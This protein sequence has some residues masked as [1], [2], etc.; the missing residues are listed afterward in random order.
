MIQQVDI[1]N[2]EQ[3]INTLFKCLDIYRRRNAYKDDELRMG[4]PDLWNN[5][6][7]AEEFMQ[8]ANANKK[9]LTKYDECVSALDDVKINMMLLSE[10]NCTEADIDNAYKTA[11]KLIT[12]IELSNMLQKEEDQLGA[13]LKIVAGAGGTE[14]C[15]FA[16]MLARM[17][18]QYF[19]SLGLT[20]NKD[21]VVADSQSDETSGG[22]KTVSF[23][24]NT[25]GMFG[26]L[27]AETGVHRLV[28]V[29]PFNAQ[30]KRM[31]SFVSVFVTPLID[32]SFEIE[33]DE[34]KLKFEY[35][36][37]SGAGGQ[38]V[39]KVE[40]G[41]RARYMYIDPDT[42]ESEEILVENTE[43]RDQPKNKANAIRILKSILYD[44]E[45]K[46]RQKA[47]DKIEDS[48]A[49]IEWGSQIRSYVMDD[50]RVKDHRTG[51]QTS[52]VAGVFNGDIHNFIKAY[53]MQFG[54]Q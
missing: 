38:N 5:P 9:W 49:K 30:G 14:A 46:R 35:F 19:K 44:K 52:N 51:Y 13:I 31:T 4:D 6:K 3:R 45:L 2:L 23:Q 32:E 28:R 47:K 22:Y 36:R 41:V 15:D 27:K 26:F 42:N 25:A 7:I 16:G 54:G 39:N 1:D 50:Q 12:D 20:E 18:I 33:L 43:T 10:N 8:K 53:L 11:E 48:K 37:S 34:S 29:S 17:Y 40:S 21:F 24:V